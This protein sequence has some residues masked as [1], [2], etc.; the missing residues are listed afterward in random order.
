MPRNSSSPA[1]PLK[2]HGEKN[3]R[4]LFP[5][6]GLENP[7]SVKKGAEPGG[8]SIPFPFR[9]KS[10]SMADD[11]SICR[12]AT[13]ISA[14][15]LSSVSRYSSSRSR[16]P[17]NPASEPEIRA[18]GAVHPRADRDA[19]GEIP[20]RGGKDRS[21]RSKDH[22]R[23]G[24]RLSIIRRASLFGAP[25]TDP[26]GKVLAIICESPTSGAE[27]PLDFRLHLEKGAVAPD[28]E[29]LPNP[30]GTVTAYSSRGRFS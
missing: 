29:K 18:L 22:L 28:G 1:H 11:Y 4:G 17:H 12:D 27:A 9:K 21:P 19:H 30:Y 20:V 15:A 24:S 14:F 23:W 8:S 3:R 26:G 13:D 6:E 16:I 2:M 7:F 25:V 10:S 5:P